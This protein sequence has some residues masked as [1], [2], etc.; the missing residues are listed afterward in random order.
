MKRKKNAD[1]PSVRRDSS[2]ASEL[3]AIVYARV[4]YHETYSMDARIVMDDSL[5]FARVNTA[6]VAHA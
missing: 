4:G 1:Y 6:V 2:E 5:H 3:E